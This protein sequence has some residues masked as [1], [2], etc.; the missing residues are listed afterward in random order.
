[1][2]MEEVTTYGLPARFHVVLDEI[3]PETS[4]ARTVA[5]L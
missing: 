5:E 3:V 4:V 1:M 2:V